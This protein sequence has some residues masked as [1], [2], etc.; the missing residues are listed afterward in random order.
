V[1]VEEVLEKHQDRL[2]SIPGVEGVGIGGDEGAPEI[3]IM[4][5]R[6]GAEMRRKLPARIG[7]YPVR[8]DVTG[9]ITAS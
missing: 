4:V 9:E 7:G 8:V 6:G 3:V 5:A 2:M 1:K